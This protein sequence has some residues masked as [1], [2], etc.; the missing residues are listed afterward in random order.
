[1]QGMNGFPHSHLVGTPSG[2]QPYLKAT[3]SIMKRTLMESKVIHFQRNGGQPGRCT[4]LADDCYLTLKF[5]WEVLHSS[6]RDNAAFLMKMLSYDFLLVLS[7][8]L[9]KV[10]VEHSL[11]IYHCFYQRTTHPF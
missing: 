4:I 10:G 11:L 5:G 2:G 8:L 7:M 9:K 3:Y 6:A 1:M